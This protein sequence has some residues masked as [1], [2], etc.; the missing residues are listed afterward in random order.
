MAIFAI[1]PG[2][3]T[4]IFWSDSDGYDSQTLDLDKA[5]SELHMTQHECL[6]DW[7]TN[8]IRKG[9]EVVCEKFEYQK[10]KAQE[11]EALNFDAGE[12]V[13]VVKI[14][15]ALNNIPLHMQSPSMVVSKEG[16]TFWND[17]KLK[18][19]GLWK[20]RSR[21]ERDATRHFLYFVTFTLGIQEW[22]YKLK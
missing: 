9:D 11:R 21:H 16:K 8:H 3:H 6:W 4:G 17:D 2:P 12:Y 15:C 10:D 20:G 18:R 7:L 22:L 13:G 1:D 19:V 5:P 14:W